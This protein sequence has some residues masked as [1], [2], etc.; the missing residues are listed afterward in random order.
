MA[1][2]VL[3]EDN[4]QPYA[5]PESIQVNAAIHAQI[6]DTIVR[7]NFADDDQGVRQV[8]S[9]VYT[10]AC[11]VSSITCSNTHPHTHTPQIVKGSFTEEVKAKL[12]RALDQ[13][14]NRGDPVYAL[15]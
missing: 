7:A 4:T 11:F 12:Q 5:T 6:A 2:R 1:A 9:L 13:C 3:G 14:D 15:M 8:R 10:F